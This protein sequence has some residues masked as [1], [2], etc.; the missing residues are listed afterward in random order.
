MKAALLLNTVLGQKKKE[1]R[2][3]ENKGPPA[4]TMPF[5][6]QDDFWQTLEI[7]QYYAQSGGREYSDVTTPHECTS[8][9]AQ[10]FGIECGNE[11]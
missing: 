6:W 1:H 5:D 7:R 4:D 9:N 8:R 2:R 3:S 11:D 10:Q